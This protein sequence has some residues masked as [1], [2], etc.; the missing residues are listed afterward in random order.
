M[1]QLFGVIWPNISSSIT[2]NWMVT[3]ITSSSIN[4]TTCVTVLE[5]GLKA[6]SLPVDRKFSPRCCLKVGGNALSGAMEDYIF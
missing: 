3:I 5:M 6:A 2:A 4:G 1:K